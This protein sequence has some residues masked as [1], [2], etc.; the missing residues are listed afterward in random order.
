MDLDKEEVIYSR[1]SAVIQV[2]LDHITVQSVFVIVWSIEVGRN[3]LRG[4]NKSR[5]IQET[6]TSFFLIFKAIL[7]CEKE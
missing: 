3:K 1:I 4:R 2:P 6:S 7:S 5:S